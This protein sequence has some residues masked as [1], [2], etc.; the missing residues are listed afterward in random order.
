MKKFLFLFAALALVFSSCSVMCS[1][2]PVLEN[3][4]WTAQSRMFVADAGYE[5]TTAALEFL[6][7][8]AF[9]LKMVSVLPPHP[10]MYMNADGTVDTL[11]GHHSEFE[12]KGTYSISGDKLKLLFEDGGSC[13]LSVAVAPGNAADVIAL[14]GLVFGPEEMLFSPEK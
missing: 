5:T 12:Q 3:T 13:E 11:P 4:K 2:K 8:K 10:A 9:V 6:P 7:G 1:R 14:R